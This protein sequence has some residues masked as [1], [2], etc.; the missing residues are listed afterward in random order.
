M[1]VY[2]IFYRE[3]NNLVA[4]IVCLYN[5]LLLNDYIVQRLFNLYIINYYNR[6]A[7]FVPIYIISLLN[8]NC[9]ATFID[10]SK[11]KTSR[12]IGCTSTSYD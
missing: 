1:S 4:K 10:N 5:L 3:I 9:G 8:F 11:L 2:F 6:Q 12:E 7:T